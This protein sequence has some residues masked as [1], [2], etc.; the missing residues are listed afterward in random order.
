MSRMMRWVAFLLSFSIAAA[1]P[2]EAKYDVT[3]CYQDVS[4][5]Q[6]PDNGDDHKV[7]SSAHG[8][9]DLTVRPAG[10]STVQILR[11]PQLLGTA[12]LQDLSNQNIMIV[13]EQDGH[14]VALNYSDGGAI[15]GWHTRVF[16]TTN[17]SIVDFTAGIRQ[18]IQNFQSKHY[19][20]ERGNNVQGLKW[21]GS[22]TLLLLLEVYPTSDCGRDLGHS[23]GYV[24]NV[25][26]G[27]IRKHL[28]LQSLSHLGGICLQNRE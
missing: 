25:R 5:L 14:A 8:P 20:K 22:E 17:Q 10:P 9:Q 4:S 18:A 1:M 3:Y 6:L 2:E 11:G 12:D 15:G 24:V 28:S 21:L 7:L 16:L 19:C 27:Q 26:T 13:W 23:E